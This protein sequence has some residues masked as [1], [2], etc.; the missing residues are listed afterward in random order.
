MGHLWGNQRKQIV[1]FHNESQQ[2]YIVK[3]PIVVYCFPRT[4]NLFVVGSI[5]TRPIN[6][7]K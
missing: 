2:S 7:I 4:L 1:K 5:P 6:R 3:I